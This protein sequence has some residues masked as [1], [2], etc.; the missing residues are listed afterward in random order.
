MIRAIAEAKVGGF[1][2]YALVEIDQQG[3]AKNRGYVVYSEFG[4]VG[5]FGTFRAALA[6]VEQELALANARADWTFNILHKCVTARSYRDLRKQLESLEA[7]LGEF[8]IE[9]IAGKNKF[10]DD[11]KAA[12][13]RAV[14]SWGEAIRLIPAQGPGPV[15]GGHSP[16]DNLF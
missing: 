6:C 9:K 16:Q 3:N 11:L 10:R 5:S 12:S 4:F 13:K 14:A 7:S 8:D 15:S 1:S 2:I